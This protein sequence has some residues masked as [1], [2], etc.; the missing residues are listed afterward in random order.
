M[1]SKG[2][3]CQ[4]CGYPIERCP[5]LM[6]GR[7]VPGWVAVEDRMKIGEA[8]DGKTLYVETYAIESCPLYVRMPKRAPAV[9]ERMARSVRETTYSELYGKGKTDTEIANISGTCFESVVRWRKNKGLERN[10]SKRERE[11]KER[12]CMYQH[13]MTDCEIADTCGLTAKAVKS[14]RIRHGLKANIRRKG[15]AV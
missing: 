11:H 7:P 10:P 4:I 14:W 13:G 6:A 2:N 8:P 12:L 15:M 1:I 5:W 9:T 3:P